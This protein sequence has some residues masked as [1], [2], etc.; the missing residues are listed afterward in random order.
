MFDEY[1]ENNFSEVP[2]FTVEELMNKTDDQN[3]VLV[4]VRN[5]EERAVSFIPYSITKEEFEKNTTKYIDAKIVTY[6][7]IGY[8]TGIYPKKL[9]DNNINAEN[10]KGGVLGRAHHG[11]SF[12][13]DEGNTIKKVH[14]FGKDWAL[15][16][17]DYQ[18]LWQ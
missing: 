15:V 16:P 4:D 7:T 5:S 2:T 9:R 14:V 8:R 12:I 17:E 10:L 11:N 1:Q 18:A 13:N 6:C 3:L